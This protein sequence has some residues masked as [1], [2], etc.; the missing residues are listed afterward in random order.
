MIDDSITRIDL[1]LIQI[2]E[3][4]FALSDVRDVFMH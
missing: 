2:R 3:Y 4:K 1:K